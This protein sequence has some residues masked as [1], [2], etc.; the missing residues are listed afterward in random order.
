MI[1]LFRLAVFGFVVMTIF[2]VLIR[3]Y[4]RS[5]RREKLEKRWAAEGSNGDRDA[6]VKEGL[7]AYDASIRPRLIVLVYIIPT[8]TAGVILYVT[9]FM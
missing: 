5:V 8:V 1:A 2:Y 3:I 9:S 6:Y 4:S 7:R